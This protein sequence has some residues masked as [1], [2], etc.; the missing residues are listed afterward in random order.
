MVN[1]DDE[2]NTVVWRPDNSDAS[3]EAKLDPDVKV[4]N[5]EYLETISQTISS[6]SAELRELSMAVHS[7]PEL[8]YAEYKTHDILVNFMKKQEGW[9]VTPK[10]E[11]ETAWLATYESPEAKDDTRV[12]GVN[13]EMDALPK[14]GH[15]CGHNLIA[16]TGVAV[17]LGIKAVFEKFKLPGKI[18]LLG[19]PAEEGGHGKVKLLDAGAYAK[20][21]ACL[22]AHP[23]P[24][25]R[26]TLSL[27]SCLAL[28]KI[29]AE[30]HGQTAH[31]ALSPWEGK[32]ALDAAVLAYTNIAAM[33]QQMYPT[34][35]A[36]GII[37]GKDWAVN[38]I[39]AYAK[40]IVGVRAPTR[41]EQ[42]VAMKKIIPCLEAAATATGCTLK[43]TI[44]E[45]TYDLRQNIGLGQDVERTF[46]A[47]YGR[48]ERE[49]WGIKSASTDFGNIGYGA[50]FALIAPLLNLAQ[51]AIVL[52]SLHPGY[53]IPTVPDGGNH[54][55][56]FTAAAATDEAHRATLDVAES[57]ALTGVRVVV[58]GEWY[59]KEVWERF[60]EDKVKREQGVVGVA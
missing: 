6:R 26:N 31:A 40:Y 13:S 22:M 54:T 50:Y 30:Y 9:K 4:W 48:A 3:N 57:L 12:I 39:P 18:A 49:K 23:A 10:Y 34:W 58:D 43:L 5:P 59:E 37:E 2:W 60:Q 27:T 44:D 38:V 52:P 51:L 28:R 56:A 42:D 21:A 35:R 47:K 8:G 7:N 25:P 29:E 15:A 46:K 24:G 36:H 53:S 1:K 19:T 11:L 16:I 45:G 20:M 17:A 32:N 41:A 14:I 55:P 33:R